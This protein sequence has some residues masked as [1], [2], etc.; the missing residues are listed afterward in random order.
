VHRIRSTLGLPF[1]VSPLPPFRCV[2]H[3]ATTPSVCGGGC[4]FQQ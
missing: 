1:D 4:D 2:H 3:T